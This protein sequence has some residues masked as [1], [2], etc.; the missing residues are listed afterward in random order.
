MRKLLFIMALMCPLLV[1]GAGTSS[2]SYSSRS[3]SSS[4]SS[5]SYSS[6]P[7]RSYSSPSYNSGGSSASKSSPV[8]SPST[9]VTTTSK[10]FS[11]PTYSS[12][13]NVYSS[14]TYK[15]TPTLTTQPSL[16]PRGPAAQPTTVVHH[17]GSGGPGGGNFWFWMW[18]MDSHHG[19]QPIYIQGPGGTTVAAAPVVAYSTPWYVILAN[20]AIVLALLSG[21]AWFF[22]WGWKKLG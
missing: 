14:P 13:S 15:T 1:L 17:Y 8:T 7:S 4:S 10:S 3:Y 5:K 20:I 2:S 11:S 19:Q 12:P 22:W 9:S 6:S 18:A 21:I 16:Q